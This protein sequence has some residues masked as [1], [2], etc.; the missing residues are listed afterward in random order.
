MIGQGRPKNASAAS[1]GKSSPPD[2]FALGGHTDPSSSWT[3]RTRQICGAIVTLWAFLLAAPAVAQQP[4]MRLR[5]EWGGG[6]EQQWRGTV[7]L[8]EGTLAAPM[9][10]G[11]EAD[12]PASIWVD[13]GKLRIQ[14]R[15][16][17]AYDGVDLDVTAPA[18]AMLRVNLSGAGDA[19]ATDVEVP[20]A[21]V[22]QEPF[23]VSLDA[24]G[25]RL[26]SAPRAGGSLA[27]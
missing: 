10:L 22:A 9:P 23:A 6:R 15:S 21:Q 16:A 1:A 5:L 13:S 25:S 7:V 27:R 24:L 19:A 20:L 3:V 2:R 26:L 12:E 17:R 14:P 4:S 8:D 11:I 18:T